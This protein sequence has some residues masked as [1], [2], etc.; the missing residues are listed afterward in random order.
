M[1]FFNNRLDSL[2][3]WVQLNLHYWHNVS[4]VFSW[5]LLSHVTSPYLVCLVHYFLGGFQ[6]FSVGSCEFVSLSHTF[7]NNFLILLPHYR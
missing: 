1:N 7:S 2:L 4:L 6:A 5:L 3:G